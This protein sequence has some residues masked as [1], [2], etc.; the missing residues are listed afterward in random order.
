MSAWDQ[1]LRAGEVLIKAYLMLDIDL[2]DPVG[3]DWL[4]VD[5]YWD[6]DSRVFAFCWLGDGGRIHAFR[7]DRIEEDDFLVTL[8]FDHGKLELSPVWN[9]KQTQ[10]IAEWRRSHPPDEI[11]SY[12]RLAAE[13]VADSPADTNPK[14]EQRTFRIL[15]EL[16]RVPGAVSED[17]AVIG[18]WA[19]D[20]REIAM[21]TLPGHYEVQRWCDENIASALGHNGKPLDMLEYWWE[22]AN[23]YTTIRVKRDPVTASSARTAAIK[24]ARQ[25]AR[26][27]AEARLV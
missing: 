19:A 26:E 21:W 16:G 4:C 5:Y 1:H 22:S 10:L 25:A 8:F 12:L 15:V 13:G 14:P 3:D 6:T 17:W 18:A 23:Y 11:K 7:I 20:E 9:V 24:A 2:Y 27:H